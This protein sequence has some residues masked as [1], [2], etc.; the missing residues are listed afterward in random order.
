MR[1]TLPALAT[2]HPLA[3]T[4]PALLREDAMARGLC[5]GLD[6]V[7]APVLSTLDSFPAYLDLSTAPVDLVPWLG[8]W[9]GVPAGTSGG[10]GR[11]RAVLAAAADLQVRGGTA[12]GIAHAVEA[13]HGV[14]VEVRENGAASWSSTPGGELP[15]QPGPAIVV[16]VQLRPGEVVDV[17]RLD[18][19]VCTLKP[20]H[21]EHRVQVQGP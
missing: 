20:A 21:V 9:L 14:T 4:L 16:V 2:P 10:D 6:E 19:L 3:D 15:G 7:L 11:D 1:G 8:Q 12:A 18:A 5:A 17:D 13:A